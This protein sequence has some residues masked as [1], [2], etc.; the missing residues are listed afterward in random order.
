[1]ASWLSHGH[2][3]KATSP[4]VSV[5]KPLRSTINFAHNLISSPTEGRQHE[6]ISQ[7]C[8]GR[9]HHLRR[10]HLCRNRQRIWPTGF[11]HHHDRVPTQPHQPL[12]CCDIMVFTFPHIGNVGVN[13]GDEESAHYWP[14]GVI[15]RDP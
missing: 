5:P 10:D 2:W 4:L 14:N 11:R 12:Q 13:S 1:M 9:W 7:T 6:H 15:V 3:V 8:P